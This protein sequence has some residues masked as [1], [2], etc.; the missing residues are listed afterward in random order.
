MDPETGYYLSEARMIQDIQLM[1]MYNIN[2]VRTCHYPDDSRWY[3]LCD[4]YG[5]YVV[6]EANLESHGMGYGDKTLAKVPEFQ[7]AHIQR[8]ERNVQKFRNHASVII[9]SMGNEAGFGQNFIDVYN[10][11][12]NGCYTSSSI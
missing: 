2:A 11:I 3:D 10:H 8:N 5:L 12:K 4:E 7:L 1:K 9:W 6:A